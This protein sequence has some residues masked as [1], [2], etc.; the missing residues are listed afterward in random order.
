[1]NLYSTGA[2]DDLL[3][4][5]SKVRDEM[6]DLVKAHDGIYN[7]VQDTEDWKSHILLTE[8]IHIPVVAANKFASDP[9]GKLTL[10]CYIVGT[11]LMNNALAK[12][13]I[14]DPKYGAIESPIELFMPSGRYSFQKD[15]FL[16][17]LAGSKSETEGIV[18]YAAKSLEKVKKHG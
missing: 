11:V 4:G 5:M 12:M 13:G 6:A 1:M 8:A 18:D 3:L 9:S 14:A 16:K 2:N 10:G 15:E 17:K 7:W